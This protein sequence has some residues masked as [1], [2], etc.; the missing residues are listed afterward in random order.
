[1]K[2]KNEKYI[3]ISIWICCWQSSSFFFLIGNFSTKNGRQQWAFYEYLFPSFLNY[4]STRFS[5]AYIYIF[6][7]L[8]W[9]ANRNFCNAKNSCANIENGNCKDKKTTNPGFNH[10]SL[11]FFRFFSFIQLLDAET[12]ANSL[13]KIS[14]IFWI[15]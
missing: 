10:I 1:M 12:S 7:K 13:A 5:C 9:N 2:K 11:N 14:N 15:F 4:Q 3:S 6:N 8:R